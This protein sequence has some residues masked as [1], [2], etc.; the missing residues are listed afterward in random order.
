MQSGSITHWIQRL[1]QDDSL[2]AQRVWDYFSQRLLQLASELLAD[3]SRRVVDEEDV[4]AS[5]FETLF[6]RA[7]IESSRGSAI[8]MICGV[9]W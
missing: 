4:V 1:D 2:A 6:R 8:A 3:T 5:V 9:C 7:R